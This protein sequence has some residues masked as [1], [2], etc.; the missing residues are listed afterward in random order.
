MID[1]SCDNCG[2]QFYR[3]DDGYA[4]VAGSVVRV[5]CVKCYKFLFDLCDLKPLGPSYGSYYCCYSCNKTI[6]NGVTKISRGRDSLEVA[7]IEFHPL[8]FAEMC[9]NSFL[10]DV[11]YGT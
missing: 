3:G 11:C 8:C 1:S 6:K 9:T 7:S 10:D 2:R 4:L 5:Y